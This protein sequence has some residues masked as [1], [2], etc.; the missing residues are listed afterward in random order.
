MV[1]TAS[2]EQT[3]KGT[4]A[5]WI[6]P[7]EDTLP[8]WEVHDGRLWECSLESCTRIVRPVIVREAVPQCRL[9]RMAL[10]AHV[11]GGI[12]ACQN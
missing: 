10:K 8:R 6:A 4:A 1:R 5:G 12:S 2:F 11:N 9:R 7:S 3:L